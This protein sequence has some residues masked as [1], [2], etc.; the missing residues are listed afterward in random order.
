MK[1]SI[2][3]GYNRL[4]VWARSG[5]LGVIHPRDTGDIIGRVIIAITEF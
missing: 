1:A 2:F 5:F 4:V 3:R